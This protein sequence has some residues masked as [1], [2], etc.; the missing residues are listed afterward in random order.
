MIQ[1]SLNLKMIFLRYSFKE[2]LWSCLHDKNTLRISYIQMS[3]NYNKD[4]QA[5]QKKC[6]KITKMLL[7]SKLVNNL[8]KKS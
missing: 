7:K 8:Q 5:F 3:T 2:S 4:H 6:N 1:K